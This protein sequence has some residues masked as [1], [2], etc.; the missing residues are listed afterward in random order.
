MT[1]LTLL[2]VFLV[3]W[4]AW[5]LGEYVMHRVV[6]HAMRGRGIASREH[7]NHHAD[8]DSILEKWALAWS[9]ILIVGTLLGVGVHPVFGI[10]WVFG[11][12]FYDLQHYRAHKRAPRTRYQRWLRR[13]HFHHHFGRPVVNHGVTLPLWDVVFRTYERPGVIRVPR[14]LAMVWLVDQSGRVRTEF[15]GDYEVVGRADRPADLAVRDKVDAFANRP[16][17]LV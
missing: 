4:F 5:T 1:A 17:V 10:G 13:H 11:Y 15:A 14:R 7:L 2:A 3:G 6:M 12:G 16:P 8:R 9:G